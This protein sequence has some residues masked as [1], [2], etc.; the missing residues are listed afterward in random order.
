MRLHVLTYAASAQLAHT[1]VFPHSPLPR[2]SK[3]AYGSRDRQNKLPSNV[4]T[5]L[6]GTEKELWT[7]DDGSASGTAASA[8]GSLLM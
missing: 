4:R 3:G 6:R 5:Q 2:E 7:A 8:L 1:P